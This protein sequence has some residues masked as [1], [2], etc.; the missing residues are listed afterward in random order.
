MFA[1]YT[2]LKKY[3][4]QHKISQSDLLLEMIYL[5]RAPSASP[6]LERQR[7]RPL[8]IHKTPRKLY[9][10]DGLEDFSPGLGIFGVRLF[11]PPGAGTQLFLG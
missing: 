5:C 3:R 9:G 1:T 10:Q 4:S 2:F 6:D 8:V 11:N 7:V